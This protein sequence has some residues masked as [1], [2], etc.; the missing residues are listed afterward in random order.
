MGYYLFCEI[1]L[2]MEMKGSDF[3]EQLGQLI[4]ICENTSTHELPRDR[5]SM[6]WKRV[7]SVEVLCWSLLL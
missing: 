6:K 1:H 3:I 2:L 7:A 5:E 4:L